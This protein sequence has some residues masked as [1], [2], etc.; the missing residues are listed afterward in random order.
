[1]D[2][3]H[4]LDCRITVQQLS[5]KM[6]AFA[7]GYTFVLQLKDNPKELSPAKETALIFLSF[8]KSFIG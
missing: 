3:K 5:D 8:L 2:K 6:S 4:P 1:M 7:H